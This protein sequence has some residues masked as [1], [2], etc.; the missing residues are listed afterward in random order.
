[1]T[2]RKLLLSAVI[3]ALCTGLF[4]GCSGGD[5]AVPTPLP[6]TEPV[7]TPIQTTQL[8]AQMTMAT[9]AI[10]GVLL[11]GPA[12]VNDPSNQL[13]DTPRV[14]GTANIAGFDVEE[15]T[16]EG[17]QDH[18]N[19]V[20]SDGKVVARFITKPAQRNA[21]GTLLQILDLGDSSGSFFGF[22]GR[23]NILFDGPPPAG[24]I[25]NLTVQSLRLRQ[26]NANF[27]LLASS[28]TGILAVQ[29]NR[30][31]GDLQDVSAAGS[32][33]MSV[34][35][36]I[37]S[38]RFQ[39]I[40]TVFN[41]LGHTGTAV[42]NRELAGGGTIT[43]PQGPKQEWTVEP[44]GLWNSEPPPV[45]VPTL[46]NDPISQIGQPPPSSPAFLL[47]VRGGEGVEFPI[48]TTGRVLYTAVDANGNPIVFTATNLTLTSSDTSIV[49]VIPGSV[50]GAAPRFLAVSPGQVTLALTDSGSGATGTKAVAVVDPNGPTPSPTPTPTGP[51]ARLYITSEG[52]NKIVFMDFDPAT[53][54]VQPPLA[55]DS[56]ATGPVDIVVTRDESFMLIS[57]TDGAIE[58][59]RIESDGDLLQLPTGV[60]LGAGATFRMTESLLPRAAG[61]P[62]RIFGIQRAPRQIVVLEL[63]D[64][65]TLTNPK[66]IPFTG[67][68][69]IDLDTVDAGNNLE[70][71]FVSGGDSSVWAYQ[72]PKQL[73]AGAVNSF[74]TNF[75]NTSQLA[76]LEIS[77]VSGPVLEVLDLAA[78][79]LISVPI[80][81]T[82]PLNNLLTLAQ[83]TNLTVQSRPRG[84]AVD[85]LSDVAYFGS[86]GPSTVEGVGLKSP[87][88][89]NVLLPGSP[90]AASGSGQ[91]TVI[92]GSASQLVY[93]LTSPQRTVQAFVQQAN[94]SLNPLSTTTMPGSGQVQDI[95]AVIL[96][97]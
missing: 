13:V 8:S 72:V 58:V 52:D 6:V 29:N 2:H 94:L 38:N 63:D 10:A 80:D 67:F 24:N 59:Y 83:S 35:A 91:A 87:P 3:L 41:F 70:Y 14:L 49:R 1:M 27:L 51:P 12:T 90:Y 60:N 43:P 9:R 76:D 18:L 4:F 36:V 95:K 47:E 26:S 25:V 96:N 28:L 89:P 54:Q 61:E 84:L 46:G 82:Q 40:E 57:H 92:T 85:D 20:R 81:T 62:R 75:V 53:G 93:V 11:F 74:Q 5:D 19:V 55:F 42:L 50:P 34:D 15:N 68:F 86:E 39:G 30:L 37:Q 23:V 32:R 79:N 16:I 22:E 71:V 65:G 44:G 17:S 78:G 45:S 56:T 7:V 66:T 88:T 21:D 31:Q 77:L 33:S 64:N 48:G 69:P 97:D 73:P